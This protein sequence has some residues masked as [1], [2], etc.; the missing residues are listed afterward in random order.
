MRVIQGPDLYSLHEQVIPFIRKNCYKKADGKTPE[1]YAG[2]NG[3]DTIECPEITLECKTPAYGRRFIPPSNDP[4]V[5]SLPFSQ[6]YMDEYTMQLIHGKE[7]GKPFEYDY[8]TRLRKY[9]HCDGAS[10]TDQIT[11]IL[12]KLRTSPNSRR[13]VAI[14]WKPWEDEGKED[15]PC[16]QLIHCTIRDGKLDERVVF[17][18]EDMGL[19]L[20]PNMYGLT[21]LQIYL[22]NCLGVGVGTYTHIAMCPH[23][24]IYRDED[25]LSKFISKWW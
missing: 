13:G 4:K 23:L 21:G 8:N 25:Y 16:L 22:A 3:Q 12:E 15:V 6:R 18:S 1:V 2:E 7:G 20:G 9:D 5:K 24:Y 19:G 11:Y 17:R 14:T 10:P